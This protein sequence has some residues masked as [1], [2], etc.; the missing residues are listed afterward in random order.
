MFYFCRWICVY[1]GVMFG[2]ELM[3]IE[4]LFV[5]FVVVKKIFVIIFLRF[6]NEDLIVKVRE[7]NLVV[8]NGYL[9]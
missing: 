9:R 4:N 6:V 1:L 5:K 8:V 2:V 7:E 3:E